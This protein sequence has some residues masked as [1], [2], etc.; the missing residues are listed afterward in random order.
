MWHDKTITDVVKSLGSSL[1][2][3]T[4]DEAKRR[5]DEVGPNEIKQEKKISP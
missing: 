5:L 2:G 4:S 1:H 3:L